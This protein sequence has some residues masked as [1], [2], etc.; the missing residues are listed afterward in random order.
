[1]SRVVKSVMGKKIDMASISKQ[2]EETVAVSNVYMNARGDILNAE[3]KKVIPVSKV[4]RVQHNLSEPSE[5]MGI[6]ETAQLDKSTKKKKL[7]EKEPKRM[8][9]ERVEKVDE[10]GNSYV[11]IEYDDGS[12]EVIKDKK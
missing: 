12:I 9:I 6:S 11:E 7:P 4:A 10:D 3:R 5:T 1:M 8:V 2:N